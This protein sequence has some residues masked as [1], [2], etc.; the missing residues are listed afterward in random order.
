MKYSKILQPVK[1]ALH[2][3]EEAVKIHEHRSFTETEV[4]RRQSVDRT[5]QQVLDAVLELLSGAGAT[6]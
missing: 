3:F 2:H 4:V 1:E 6:R 5:R